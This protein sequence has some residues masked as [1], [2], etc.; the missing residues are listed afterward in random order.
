[1]EVAAATSNVV[2]FKYL[3]GQELFSKKKFEALAVPDGQI[4]GNYITANSKFFAVSPIARFNLFYRC[5]GRAEEE[6]L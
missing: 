3:A 1:M 2:K 6:A 4:E 5:P